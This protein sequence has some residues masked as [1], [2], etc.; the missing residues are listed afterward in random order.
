MSE[1]MTWIA[2]DGVIAAE[3]EPTMLASELMTQLE[4][5][6]GLMDGGR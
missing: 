3:I 2:D 5:R 1:W 4:V 6:G